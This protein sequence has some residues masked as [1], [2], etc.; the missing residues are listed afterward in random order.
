MDESTIN[1][2]DNALSGWNEKLSEVFSLLTTAPDEFRGGAVWSVM[3]GIFN[4][5]VGVGLALTILCWCIGVIKN[6]GTMSELRRPEIAVR[7]IVRL[8]FTQYVVTHSL[9]LLK[10]FINLASS[11]LR[12]IMAASGFS[13]SSSMA[14]P[15]EIRDAV[16]ELGLLSGLGA[17]AIAFL[18]MFIITV[19]SF[20][21]L[22]T[23]YGRFFKIFIMTALAPIPLAGFAGEPT[24]GMGKSFVRTYVA[25]LLEGAIILLATIIFSAFATSAPVFDTT[26]SA[27]S[28]IFTYIGQLVFQMLILVV[29]VKSADRVAR[30]MSGL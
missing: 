23:V 10:Q 26:A 19:L 4:A 28:M 6:V 12:D 16:S 21:I 8:V 15:Q 7:I 30:E 22:L 27:Q 17:W 24:S 9:E 25:V 3:L 13:L 14:V 11:L 18:S 1:F 5:M 29:I 2:L 20:I